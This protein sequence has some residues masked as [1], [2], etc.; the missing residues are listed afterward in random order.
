MMQT[1]SYSE[2]RENLKAMIDKVVADR[3]PI[4]ITRQRGE[5]AVL[6]SESEW[7]GMEETLHLLS[8]PA[9]ARRLL[10]GIK[11]FDAGEGEEHELIRP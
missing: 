4:T 2:A 9:N 1:V 8:S 5:G 7:A 10:E 6:I 3:A 11:R